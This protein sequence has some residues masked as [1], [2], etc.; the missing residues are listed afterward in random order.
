VT[1]AAKGKERPE[2]SKTQ[3]ESED[4]AESG[5]IRSTSAQRGLPEVRGGRAATGFQCE[6][7]KKKAA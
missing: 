5:V 6:S 4:V 7:S 1:S 2:R 3:K